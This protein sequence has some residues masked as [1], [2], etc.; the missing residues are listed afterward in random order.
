MTKWTGQTVELELN[1]RGGTL[2]IGPFLMGWIDRA[3][4]RRRWIA[5]IQGPGYAIEIGRFKDYQQAKRAVESA[6]IA[7]VTGKA[8]L[9][10]IEVG[11]AS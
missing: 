2:R 7:H 11:E 3:W 10:Q 6:A 1:W 9:A 8:A 4:I 5:K